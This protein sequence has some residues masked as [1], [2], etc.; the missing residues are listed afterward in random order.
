MLPLF[1]WASTESKGKYT[2]KKTINKAY[3][4]NKN[5]T[6]K[7]NSNYG[8]IDVIT[9]N[10]NRVV[11]EITITTSGNDE[12][13]VQERL[14]GISVVFDASSNLVS[15]KTNFGNSKSNSWWNWSKKNKVSINVHYLVKIPVTNH[16]DLNNDYGSINLD[17]LQGNAKINCD[18]GKVTAKELLGDN[19]SFNF[20]YSQNCYFEYIKNGKI[21]ADYSGFTISKTNTIDI[22]A[23]YSNSKIEFAEEI[24]YNCDYGSLKVD[25]VNN[26]NG[27]GDYL[28]LVIGDV[29]KSIS[30][31]ADYG[32]IKVSQLN[33]NT[34]SVSISG[35]Y[36]G[37]KLGYAPNYNFNFDISLDYASLNSNSLEFSTKN[38]QS[39]SKHYIGYHGNASSGNFI[40]ITSDYGGVSLNKN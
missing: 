4:V 40:K 20:D 21:N 19:N 18:Y 2:K 35:D 6:L 28:T 34:K 29:Y 27:N 16:V 25:K 39:T 31:K 14:D 15:A 5:A 32:V 17:K 7:V 33:E 11:F 8:N 23:D 1:T 10:E 3:S 38:V 24:S 9:W 22:N 26:L 37:I 30:L 12:E 13:N 36:T